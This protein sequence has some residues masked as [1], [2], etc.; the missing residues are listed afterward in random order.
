MHRRVRAPARAVDLGRHPALEV[1]VLLHD[2]ELGLG[3]FSPVTVR[4]VLVGG[5]L[6]EFIRVVV[7]LARL[8]VHTVPLA[9][10]IQC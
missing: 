4:D 5:R 1:V 3:G 6:S 8:D 2:R 10:E 9:G 7:G